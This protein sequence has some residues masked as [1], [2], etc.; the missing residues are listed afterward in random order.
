MTALEK[1]KS[2]FRRTKEKPKAE[3]PKPTPEAAKKE[4]P[5]EKK[6]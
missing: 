4:T 5:P 2:F 1:I 3:E 6:A